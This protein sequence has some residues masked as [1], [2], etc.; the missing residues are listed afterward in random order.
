[1]P[2]GDNATPSGGVLTELT[3]AFTSATQFSD[4]NREP[5]CPCDECACGFSTGATD[6][7]SCGCGSNC[8][9]G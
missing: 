6:K 9:C 7:G 4:K 1:M 3:A 2:R 8:G 5:D